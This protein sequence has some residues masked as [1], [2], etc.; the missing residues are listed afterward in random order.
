MFAFGLVVLELTTLKRLD[1]WSSSRWPELLDSVPDPETKA[2]IAKCLGPEDQRPTV[3]EL[4]EVRIG[5][6]PLAVMHADPA[7]VRV[8]PQRCYHFVVP[9]FAALFWHLILCVLTSGSVLQQKAAAK[10]T[11]GGQRQWRGRLGGP[12]R[13]R[14]IPP[15]P[16][17]P[18]QRPRRP[19][20]DDQRGPQRGSALLRDGH[21]RRGH[22]L[23]GAQAVMP[24]LCSFQPPRSHQTAFVVLAF[25]VLLIKPQRNG[26]AVHAVKCRSVE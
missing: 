18:A 26:I 23:P 2:F 13:S 24:Q 20:R 25:V 7:K 19:P 11:V 9:V 4:L 8:M 12:R 15:R 21:Q 6:S 17:R 16:L 1:H 14:G 5:L 3:A 22:H 10:G